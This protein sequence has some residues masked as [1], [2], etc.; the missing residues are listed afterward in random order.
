MLHAT[1]SKRVEPVAK[2][3]VASVGGPETG[4][5][6]AQNTTKRGLSAL[7]WEPEKDLTEFFN[8][9]LFFRQ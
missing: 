6:Q 2:V 1:V 9:L 5:K 4:H 8:R 7:K 3:V